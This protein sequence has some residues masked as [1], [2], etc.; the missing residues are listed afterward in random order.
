MESHEENFFTLKAKDLMTTNPKTI[1]SNK[2]LTQASELMN[3]NMINA[4][5]VVNETD[6]LVG[7]VHRH[8]IAI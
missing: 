6:K 2:K 7:I 1:K 5:I 4:L 3:D 8:N